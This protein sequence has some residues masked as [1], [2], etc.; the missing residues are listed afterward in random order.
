M[1]FVAGGVV[2]IGSRV[3]E[4][5]DVI[6]RP[7]AHNARIGNGRKSETTKEPQLK[8]MPAFQQKRTGFGLSVS[9]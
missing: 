5:V 7:A 3:W 6:V 4:L 2:Y 9:F 8:L 1:L